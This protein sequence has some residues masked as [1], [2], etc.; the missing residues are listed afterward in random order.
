MVFCGGASIFTRMNQQEPRSF[1][2]RSGV[3]FCGGASFLARVKKKEPFHMRKERKVQIDLS[4]WTAAFLAALEQTF[5]GRV[6]F[7]GLQ[8]SRARGEAREESDID[9]VV[10]LDRL[11][12]EDLAACRLMVRAL[13]YAELACGFIGGR[14]EL[15]GWEP[16][17]LISFCY[18]V[19]PLRGSLDFLRPRLTREAALRAVQIGAGGIY[20][21]AC[22]G[23]VFE[24]DWDPAG[25][26][27]AAFFVLRAKHFSETGDF[28]LRQKD[29]LPLLSGEDRA[30][31][32]RRAD[33]KPCA[34]QADHLEEARRLLDWSGKLLR[35]FADK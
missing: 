12:A 4:V 2:Q 8:G 35:A 30:V 34:D 15:L 29:L 18:D 22:H 16:S 31:L 25:C 13:P 14:E 33:E 6:V 1:K 17:E 28:I 24:Q 7:A 5:G 26:R 9:A 10:V 21:A 27:K 19:T 23:F 11:T 3:V 32:L 20:H